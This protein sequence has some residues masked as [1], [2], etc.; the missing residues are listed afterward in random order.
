M[1]IETEICLY[2]DPWL[3]L[4]LDYKAHDWSYIRNILRPTIKHKIWQHKGPWL[5]P[6]LQTY[7]CG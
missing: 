7:E 5:N 1:V 2:K 6:K 4:K 3:S